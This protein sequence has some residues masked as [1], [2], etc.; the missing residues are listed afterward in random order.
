VTLYNI[1]TSH[2]KE[3]GI[4]ILGTDHIKLIQFSA[5]NNGE[6]GVFVTYNDTNSRFKP[7]DCFIANGVSAQN[8]ERGLYFEYTYR[9][10][11]SNIMTINNEGA[12][13]TVGNGSKGLDL[14]Q[15]IIISDLAAIGNN[16]A[17]NPEDGA[18]VLNSVRDINIYNH[19]WTSKGGALHYCSISD[20]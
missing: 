20:V 11:L 2:N 9:C 12:G 14:S 7:N 16:N 18:L 6:S 4:K 1:R 3:N 19:L 5:L 17:V 15:A 13:L 8:S 10:I